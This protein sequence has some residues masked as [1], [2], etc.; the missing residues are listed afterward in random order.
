MVT[1]IYIQFIELSECVGAFGGNDANRKTCGPCNDVK[2]N[3]IKM[4]KAFIVFELFFTPLSRSYRY[5]FFY[6]FFFNNHIH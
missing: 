2:V 4:P 5:I 1:N 6:L 3:L